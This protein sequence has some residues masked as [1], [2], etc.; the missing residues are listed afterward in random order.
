MRDIHLIHLSG[1]ARLES[2]APFFW[3]GRTI[4]TR[5]VRFKQTVYLQYM[6]DLLALDNHQM[7][8]LEP[9]FDTLETRIWVFCAIPDDQTLDLLG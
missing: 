2:S 7:I 9:V 4:K 3:L 5:I 6:A 8:T 1:I